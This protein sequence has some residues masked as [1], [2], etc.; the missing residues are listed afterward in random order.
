MLGRRVALPLYVLA[1]VCHAADDSFSGETRRTA[2]QTLADGL[3]NNTN[4]TSFVSALDTAGLFSD[5]TGSGPFTVFAPTNEALS[6]VPNGYLTMLMEDPGYIIHLQ[7]L[8]AFHV[9]IEAPLEAADL[10][11]G[12][13]LL[14]ANEEYLSVSDNNGVIVLS[15]DDGASATIVVPD[16]AIVSNGVVHQLDQALLPKF[17]F[18]N[19]YNETGVFFQSLLATAGMEDFLQSGDF[20]VILPSNEAFVGVPSDVFADVDQLTQILQYHILDKVLPPQQLQNGQYQT[21]NGESMV[22]SVSDGGKSVTF[23]GIPVQKLTLAN[24][25]IV[26]TI[27]A[28]LFPGQDIPTYAPQPTPAPAPSSST[29]SPA[30]EPTIG[31]PSVSGDPNLVDVIEAADDLKSISLALNTV[32][33]TENL[34]DIDSATVV[35]PIDSAFLQV[36]QELMAQLFKPEWIAHMQN[37]LALHVVSPDVLYAADISDGM[38][39]TTLNGEAISFTVGDGGSVFVNGPDGTGGVVVTADEPASNGV[40]HKLDSVL[41]P[42]WVDSDLLAIGAQIS[43]ITTFMGLITSTGLDQ[44]VAT[45]LFTI[46]APSED[47]FTALLQDGNQTLTNPANVAELTRVL[48]YHMIPKLTPTALLTNSTLETVEGSNLLSSVVPGERVMFNDATALFVDI[49]AN[50]GLF[51]IIDKV[52]E[53]QDFTDAP[54]AAGAPTASEAPNV[55]DSPSPVSSLSPVSSPTA[56]GGSS[57]DGALLRCS[58]A[59]LSVSACVLLTLT[60]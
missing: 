10:T 38:S 20:T 9:D 18:T 41:L 17:V 33:L 15:N 57:S 3:Q 54:S 46:L 12:R 45:G 52:L 56:T 14:M 27:D 59:L 16:E 5:L 60:M 29:E 44:T 36:D 26:Y 25:G 58:W 1:V 55:P 7:N 50:N 47:A 28:V 23:D 40:L 39:V 49:P 32:N 37:L 6:A 2:E 4:Y 42:S 31:Q 21:V 35:A 8:L 24:N 51:Y 53:I 43:E 30:S 11:D 34:A 22:V 19:V 13:E 48:Q